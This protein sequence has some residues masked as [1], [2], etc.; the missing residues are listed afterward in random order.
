[1]LSLGQE[2]SPA[3]LPRLRGNSVNSSDNST[4]RVTRL[5]VEPLSEKSPA[6]KQSSRASDEPLGVSADEL[7][8]TVQSIRE[9]MAQDRAGFIQ[10]IRNIKIPEARSDIN[11]MK[12]IVASFS[13]L[14]YALSARALLLLALLGAFA[15]AVL[16]MESG[17]TMGLLIL[18]A[19]SLSTVVPVTVLEIRKT[20]E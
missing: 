2:W 11:T 5:R 19:Y 10:E 18:V 20:R 6:P 16:A 7:A 1:M 13:A 14:G 9:E 4:A 17:S 3:L 15:L 12:V 8:A